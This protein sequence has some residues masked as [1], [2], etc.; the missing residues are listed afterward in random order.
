LLNTLYGIP[1]ALTHATLRQLNIQFYD[2]IMQLFNLLTLPA[3]HNFH[4]NNF[5]GDTIEWHHP[6][7]LYFLQ[8]SK[9]ALLSLI[10][11]LWV[12]FTQDTLLHTLTGLPLLNT[13]TFKTKST[14]PQLVWATSFYIS[15]A[16]IQ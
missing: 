10:L 6:P 11:D 8:H 5:S 4:I 7:F 1:Q 12:N 15:Y 3:L 9:Y 2:Q 16:G 13:S 14:Q